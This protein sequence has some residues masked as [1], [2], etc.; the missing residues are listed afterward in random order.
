MVISYLIEGRMIEEPRRSACVRSRVCWQYQSVPSSPD[1]LA[2]AFSAPF[3]LPRAP[4]YPSLTTT[5]EV[6]HQ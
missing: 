4:P 1:L 3:Q 6:A 5:E 2:L